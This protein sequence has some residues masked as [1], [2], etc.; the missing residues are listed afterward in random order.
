MAG[1]YS[2]F[3]ESMKFLSDQNRL[4]DE[5]I[6]RSEGVDSSVNWVGAQPFFVQPG[7]CLVFW[8]ACPLEKTGSDPSMT[9][10]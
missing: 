4:V 1:T 8:G 10:H 2:D 9:Q 5:S 3:L 7:G 6:D